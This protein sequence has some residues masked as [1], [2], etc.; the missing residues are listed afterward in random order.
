MLKHGKYIHGDCFCDRLAKHPEHLLAAERR[1]DAVC[2]EAR[3]I[4]HHKLE[5]GRYAG[6]GAYMFLHGEQEEIVAVGFANMWDKS[7][8]V[9]RASQTRCAHRF[10]G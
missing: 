8:C 3:C 9:I 7:L 6:P 10:V 4:V 5:P 1:R 2:G